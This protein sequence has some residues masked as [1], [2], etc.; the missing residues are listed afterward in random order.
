MWYYI[1][2]LISAHEVKVKNMD[3]IPTYHIHGVLTSIKRGMM[4]RH[5]KNKG[6]FNFISNI[7]R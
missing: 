5:E 1:I 6:N 2:L 3:E 7:L 4:F